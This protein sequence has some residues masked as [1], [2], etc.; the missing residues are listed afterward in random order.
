MRDRRWLLLALLVAAPFVIFCGSFGFGLLGLDDNQYFQENPALHHGEAA[1]L[2]DLWRQPFFFD[3]APVTQ[4]TIW[5]DLALGHGSGFALARV[6]ELLWLAVGTIAL[7]QLVRRLGGD[8]GLAWAVALIYCLHPVTA[9]S[10][11]WLA[12]RKNLVA[13]ALTWW[14]IERHIA[15]R[16]GAGRWALAASI[17]LCPLALLAKAH[18]VI[19][20]AVIAAFELVLGTGPW[21]GR[22]LRTAPTGLATLAFIL[23]SMSCLHLYGAGDQLGG[24]LQATV[25]L[26]G[27]ILARYLAHALLPYHLALFY[28]VDEDPGH[29]VRM[30]LWWLLLLAVVAS[31]NALSRQRRLVVFA[32][33]AGLISLL[34]A[35]NLKPLPLPMA[36]H[37]LQWAL[38]WLLLIAG[39]VVIDRL[40]A[41]RPLA[42]RRPARVVAAGFA[43]FVAILSA[44]R[45]PEFASPTAVSLT[46]TRNQ[47]DCAINWGNYC[48]CKLMGPNQDP[49]EAGLAGL[50]AL[51]LPDYTRILAQPFVSCVIAGTIACRRREGEAAADQL[52]A[53]MMPLMRPDY[54]AFARGM[55]LLLEQHPD[56]AVTALSLFYGPRLRPLA[57]ALGERC[58]A[59]GPQPWEM[60]PQV[61]LDQDLGDAFKTRSARDFTLQALGALSDAYVLS[62]DQASAFDLSCQVV[63][64]DPDNSFGLGVYRE[65]CHQLGLE[66]SSEAAGRQLLKVQAASGSRVTP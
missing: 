48:Q 25:L 51:R 2:R 35:I 1:G 57:H 50:I 58:R 40:Q 4:L 46:G 32:W 9:E 39:V 28:R 31:S 13:C 33:M 11:L 66:A 29:G 20:P 16:Q 26:D 30:L 15:W 18:A 55:V 60:P 19:I 44:A 42:W 64:S 27:A 6:Q 41:M 53:R 10:A 61:D 23:I 52:F 14:S 24:S 17:L 59:G 37:Y 22:L 43:V 63:N 56:Q 21:S 3:Y 7:F 65:S 34:P 47:P 38:P 49:E 36:D 5:L 45:V 8:Q 54:Q 62:G 12:E